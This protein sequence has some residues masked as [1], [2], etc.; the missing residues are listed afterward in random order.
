MKLCVV[1]KTAD[2]NCDVMSMRIRRFLVLIVEFILVLKINYSNVQTA[3]G[4][5][6]YSE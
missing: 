4:C 2:K 1:A 6:F 5:I 3:Y